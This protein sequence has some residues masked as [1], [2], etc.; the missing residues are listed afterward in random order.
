MLSLLQSALQ[1]HIDAG[2]PDEPGMYR[3]SLAWTPGLAATLLDWLNLSPLYPQFYWQ[4]RH[5][6]AEAAACGGLKIFNRLAQAQAFLAANAHEPLLRLWGLNAFGSSEDGSESCLFLPRLTWQREQESHQLIINLASDTS[7]RDDALDFARQLSR[8]PASAP[9]QPFDVSEIA[10]SHQP[11]QPQ[12]RQMI[13]GALQALSRGE[14]AKVVLAR[15]TRLDLSGNLSPVA[16][17][18]ASKQV[19]YQ[20]YH[21]MLRWSP[22]Q[23]F[24]G[25]SRGNRLDTEALAGTVAASQAAAT[26]AQLADWLMND[27]KNQRENLLV[28]DDICQRLHPAAVSLDVTPPE[29]VSLRTVQHLRRTIMA[30]LDCQDDARC[31]SML[32]PTAAVSGLPREAARRFIAE[33]EPFERRWYAGS[34][35]YLSL[36]LAEFCVSLRCALVEHHSV[37]LYAGAGIVEGSDPDQEWRE[38]DNKAASMRTL[39]T[40]GPSK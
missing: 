26:A 17:M 9:L 38:I 15:R 23:A 25:S 29:I 2:I 36:P 12:W 5:G 14:F 33:H 6:D 32:Q 18:A 22:R 28:V 4:D 34:A 27:D 8:F 13:T 3:I 16:L 20:C 35:G 7:L 1:Q 37:W 24:L 10:A 31:L 21:F 30:Q 39:F 11:E 19:N 40:A